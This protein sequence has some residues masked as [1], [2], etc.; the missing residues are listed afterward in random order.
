MTVEDNSQL[1]VVIICS[2]GTTGPSKGVSLS[3][4][5]VTYQ[6]MQSI[7]QSTNCQDRYFCY[8]SL[9]WISG[10]M[11]VIT[12]THFNLIRVITTQ[13]FSSGLLLD[14]IRKNRIQIL[15][16][17]PSQ[18]ALLLNDPNLKASDLESLLFYYCGGSHV[19][20]EMSAAMSKLLVNGIVIVGY[21]LSEVAGIIAMTDAKEKCST[22]QLGFGVKIKI[23]DE[24]GMSLDVN[25]RGE[26]SIK[27]TYPFLGYYGNKEASLNCMDEE[28]WIRTGD[29]GFVDDDCDLHV[30]DRMKDIL[31]YNN[32]QVN[33]SEIEALLQK[34]KDVIMVAVVGIPHPISTD[35]PA[36]LIVR[37]ANSNLTEDEVHKFIQANSNQNK[38]L[39]GGVFFFDSL[40][41]TPS[42]KILKRQCKAL[43]T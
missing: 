41:M 24:A 13:K 17:P 35:L 2:S 22:G 3:H 38:W 26:I 7:A 4:A 11:S 21:G 5:A 34:L 36:A 25:Q 6:I 19:P 20:Q 18:M 23:L 42:G 12:T 8:S 33:P 16:T 32:Y 14:I 29:I 43:V 28:G 27:T 40:P 30:V 10:F 15:L 31:K 39:H 37:K 9:Y 1:S